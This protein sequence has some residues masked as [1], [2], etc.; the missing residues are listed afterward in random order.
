[1][2]HSSHVK[3]DKTAGYGMAIFGFAL[4]LLSALSYLTHAKTLSPTALI[5]GIV[6]LVVGVS[7]VRKTSQR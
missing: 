1:M 5:M 7:I 2:I 6:L 3:K 4:I